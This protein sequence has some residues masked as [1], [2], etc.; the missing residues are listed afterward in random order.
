MKDSKTL[1][2]AKELG[3]QRFRRTPFW[4]VSLKVEAHQIVAISGEHGSGKSALLLALSGY[5]K[6]TNGTLTIADATLPS[7]FHESRQYVGLGLFNGINEFYKTQTI[8]EVLM[9]EL[10]LAA[11]SPLLLKQYKNDVKNREALQQYAYNVLDQWKVLSPHKT[12]IG[13]LTPCE[14]MRLAIALALL[15]KPL[16]LF[17]D[18]IET[19]L[20]SE[21]SESLL[22]DIREY[23]SKNY[24]S[25]LV[26]VL[27]SEL[28]KQA[29]QVLRLMPN[30]E[31]T[32]NSHTDSHLGEREANGGENNAR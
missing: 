12:A 5:M 8:E 2:E 9:S 27:Q 10:K 13:E 7:D 1:L 6:F 16:L 20:T 28:E 31:K 18:G 11:R 21:Q 19:E 3:L 4:D 25:C 30:N 32:E 14:R 29:D 24:C 15:K 23:V 22:S 17:V 26:G